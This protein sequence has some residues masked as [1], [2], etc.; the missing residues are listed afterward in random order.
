MK[1]V[2]CC[3]GCSQQLRDPGEEM[4]TGATGADALTHT[5]QSLILHCVFL[6]AG[7]SYSV[8]SF[9]S[10]SSFSFFFPVVSLS[11][12]FLT[13][14][15]YFFPDVPLHVF[16]SPSSFSSFLFVSYFFYTFN[17]KDFYAGND[18]LTT[19]SYLFSKSKLHSFA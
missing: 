8:F 6:S 4:W 10:L 12:S 19:T 7:C 18:Y 3:E 11:S 14:S 2:C 5:G 16:P 15:V 17:Y 1:P 9:T 13:F